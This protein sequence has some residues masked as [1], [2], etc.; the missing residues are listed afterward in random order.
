MKLP[1]TNVFNKEFDDFVYKRINN[2]AKDLRNNDDEYIEQ[3]DKIEKIE[4]KLKK[5]LTESQMKDVNEI[6]DTLNYISG[7]EILKTYK[8]AIN[9]FNNL[10]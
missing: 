6:I 9:D 4:K 1:D 2:M 3:M 8:M 10:K 7:I 5:E